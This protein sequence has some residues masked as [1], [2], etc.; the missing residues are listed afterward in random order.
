MT[1]PKTVPGA[2]V[3]LLGLCCSESAISQDSNPNAVYLPSTIPSGVSLISS[4]H[5]KLVPTEA[6]RAVSAK[7]R[8]LIS[9]GSSG[10]GGAGNTGG[11]IGGTPISDHLAFRSFD[12]PAGILMGRPGLGVS[13]INASGDIVGGYCLEANCATSAGFLLRSGAFSSIGFS[14]APIVAA[15][16]I[17]D[18]G[19]IVGWYWDPSFISTH[20]LVFPQSTYDLCGFGQQTRFFGVSNSGDVAGNCGPSDGYLITGQGVETVS[21]SSI[22]PSTIQVTLTGVNSSD[23]YVGYL[24]DVDPTAHAIVGDLMSG[25]MAVDYP[26]AS[27]TQIFGIN[28]AGQMV[29]QA[30]DSQTGH[31]F[32]CNLP[33][34]EGCFK[35]FDAKIDGNTQGLT[36]P[37]GISSKGEIVGQY[38]DSKG[39]HGFAAVP[40]TT[41]YYV[42][43]T[44]AETVSKWGANLA[45]DQLNYGVSSDV[46]IILLFGAPIVDSAGNYGASLYSHPAPLSTVS[47]LVEAFVVGYYN[48]LGGNKLVHTRIVIATTNGTTEKFG[49]QVNAVH[50]QQW[51][52]M[53]NAVASWVVSKGYSSQID[54]AGGS[55]MEL[56]GRKSKNGSLSWA[57]PTDTRAWVDGYSG[58]SPRRLLY[59]VGDAG[60][61]PF[62][63]DPTAVPG[64]CSAGWN[65]NDLWYVAWNAPPSEPLP[66]IYRTDGVQATQ[67]SFLAEYANLANLGPSMRFAGTLTQSQACMQRE[68]KPLERNDPGMGW[69]QLSDELNS[70][71]DTG[72]HLF[73]VTDIKHVGP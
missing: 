23:Q 19:L 11:S 71:P 7:P 2:A 12:L 24:L 69:E 47:S 9:G 48:H 31:G 52:S 54:V 57:G 45:Q 51:A 15:E 6:S 13:G 28:D 35:S 27:T 34:S 1:L 17:N 60:G 50:G 4:S 63:G 68:C 39:F 18:T 65:Q 44:N 55:D 64:G 67:W 53:V 37:T 14:G 66:Q 33:L 8:P 72:Q 46:V 62:K 70:D 38:A 26:G 49:N 61:C 22:S 25:P 32:I 3:A 43:T 73:W 16:G 36:Q 41:S 58:V 59:D 42:E 5:L 10:G 21:P 29:G 56:S 20:G 40:F 30:F